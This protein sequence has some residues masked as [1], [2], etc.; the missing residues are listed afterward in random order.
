MVQLFAKSVKPFRILHKMDFTRIFLIS[1]V[2]LLS[3][4]MF[5]KIDQAMQ[6]L[7]Q[8]D[9]LTFGFDILPSGHVTLRSRPHGS[10]A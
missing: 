10:E 2:N 7:S 1:P 3:C 9:I 8:N 6:Y 5:N 4:A